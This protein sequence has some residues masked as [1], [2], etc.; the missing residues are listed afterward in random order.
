MTYAKL[1]Y[2]DSKLLDHLANKL[3][4]KKDYSFSPQIIANIAWAFGTLNHK[5]NELFDKI[6]KI[7]LNTI[8]TFSPSHI[9]ITAWAFAILNRIDLPF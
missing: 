8:Y 4:E 9:S 1:G 6:S 5:N 7:S 3:C 2:K